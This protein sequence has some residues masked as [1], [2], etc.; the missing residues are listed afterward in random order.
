L[1]PLSKMVP[2]LFAYEKQ[3]RN[4]ILSLNIRWIAQSS[5]QIF[6]HPHWYFISSCKKNHW[7]LVCKTPI[8]KVDRNKNVT[9]NRCS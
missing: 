5:L 4:F 1:R 3:I 6:I 9:L 2:M 8:V 7:S